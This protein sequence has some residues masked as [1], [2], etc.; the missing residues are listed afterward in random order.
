MMSSTTDGPATGAEPSAT[1]TSLRRPP[2]AWRRWFAW[3]VVLLACG[4]GA[5]VGEWYYRQWQYLK[6]QDLYLNYAAPPDRV[7]FEPDAAEAARLLAAGGGY[8]SLTG[9]SY[10]YGGTSRG[11]MG[12]RLVAGHAPD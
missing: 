3:A 2:R 8:R 9:R 11:K 6:A 4:A 12:W 10:L 1:K 5:F 7:V